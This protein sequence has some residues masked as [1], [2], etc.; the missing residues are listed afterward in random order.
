M[1]I[2]L[3]KRIL[4]K[5]EQWAQ[6]NQKFFEE[7][8]VTCVNVIS[9]PGS[10]KTTTLSRT[11][12]D[13]NS[14]LTIGVIEGDIK[15]D[16]DAQ[17]IRQTGAAAVQVETQGACHL[18]AQQ[19]SNALAEIKAG[20]LDL[21][22]IENVGNLVCPTSFELG[23]KARVIILSVPEGDDKPIKYP[24]SFATADAVL[25]NKIDLVE[26]IDFDTERVEKDIKTVNPGAAIFHISARTGE[27]MQA[28]YEWLQE[29]RKA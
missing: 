29:V 21:V 14:E 18:S 5:N 2:N 11:I 22:F 20:E 6:L 13:L 7:N 27:G 17:K 8:G 12:T 24:N 15:T 25:I 3:N 10:G 1:K 4:D 9:S 28:W 23:E 16:T 19:V 26:H